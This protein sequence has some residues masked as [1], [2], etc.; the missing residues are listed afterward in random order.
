MKAN[1]ADHPKVRRLAR[2]LAITRWQV[3]GVLE[4]VW[5]FAAQYAEDG[6]LCPR[7]TP[8]E[9][10]D[11]IEWDD[12][13]TALFAAMVDAGLLDREDDEI[14]IHDWAEHAPDYVKK[15]LQKRVARAAKKSGLSPDSR[16]TVG[17]QSHDSPPTVSSIPSV[18]ER[19]VDKPS[20]AKTSCS[21]PSKDDPEPVLVFPT[22]GSGAK[23]FPLTQAKLDE[24]AES[25]PGVDVLAECRKALQWCRDNP[26]KRKTAKGVPRFLANWL[27]KAQNSGQGA[28]AS[29]GPFVA[30][31][32]DIDK[33]LPDED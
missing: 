10:A 19:S 2:K 16:E 32:I 26:A 7:Y 30:P 12:D 14:V 23:E 22:V 15:R 4:S 8:A 21:T 13:A 25:Y 33:I 28:R 5:Q 3:I 18:E 6:V 29:P 11:F 1:A 9:I 17:R 31:A 24:Y 20:Q 27:S